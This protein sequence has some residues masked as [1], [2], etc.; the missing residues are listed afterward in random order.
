[1][2]ARMSRPSNRQ[3]R[4]LVCHALA[5]FFDKEAKQLRDELK[6]GSISAVRFSI[7]ATVAGKYEVELDPVNGDLTVGHDGSNATNVVADSAHLTAYLLEQLPAKRREKILDTLPATFAEKGG[8]LP[9]LEKPKIDAARAFLER[10]RVAGVPTRKRGSVSFRP[11][12]E[13]K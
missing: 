11:I 4:S 5:K 3:L 10:L 13:T 2:E 1:M 6:G 12:A 8:A 9:D 7:V